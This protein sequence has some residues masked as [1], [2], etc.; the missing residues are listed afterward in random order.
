MIHSSRR[1]RKTKAIAEALAMIADAHPELD[2]HRPR[3]V[4]ETDEWLWE[5]ATEFCAALDRYAGRAMKL[6]ERIDGLHPSQPPGPRCVAPIPHRL[7]IY[8]PGET[9]SKF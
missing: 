9:L 6:R 7:S 2:P 5:S 1:D 8:P 4:R 3:P